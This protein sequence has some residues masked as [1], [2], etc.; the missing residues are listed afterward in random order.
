[1]SVVGYPVR[2]QILFKDK[3]GEADYRL[4]SSIS[5]DVKAWDHL[6]AYWFSSAH[7]DEELMYTVYAFSDLWMY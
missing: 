7:T 2:Q 5:R 6:H 3:S 4:P 1:M